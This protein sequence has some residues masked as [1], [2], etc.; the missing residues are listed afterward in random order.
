ME[1]EQGGGERTKVALY[2]ANRR[3]QIRKDIG[4]SQLNST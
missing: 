1:G 3:R 2:E 4:E